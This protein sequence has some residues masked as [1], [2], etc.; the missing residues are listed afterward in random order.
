MKHNFTR[1]QL[2]TQTTI[3]ALQHTFTFYDSVQHMHSAF[4][5]N[6]DERKNQSIG[7]IT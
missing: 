2:Q 5:N 4:T 1:K 7:L 6:I 3:H